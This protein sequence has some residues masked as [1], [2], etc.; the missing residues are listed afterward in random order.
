M[1]SLL[2]QVFSQPVNTFNFIP[3]SQ[4][5]EAK[6]HTLFEIKPRKSAVIKVQ[7]GNVFRVVL[8][9]IVNLHQ[10]YT[11]I[12]GIELPGIAYCVDDLLMPEIHVTRG[13]KFT[14]IV[15]TGRNTSDKA[16]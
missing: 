7:N 3:R 14:F 15:E 9:L 4:I 6:A 2:Q 16:H 8:G 11:S 13:I 5:A 12:T 10:E 1:P